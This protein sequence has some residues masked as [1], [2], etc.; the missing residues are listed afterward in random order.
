MECL[1]V[2]LDWQAEQARLQL[3]NADVRWRCTWARTPQEA[4]LRV[5]RDAPDVLLLCDAACAPLLEALHAQPPLCA[6]W[7]LADGWT[8]D[9][10][11]ASFTAL[12]LSKMPALL[13]ALE[14]QGRLPGLIQSWLPQLHALATELLDM[15]G[16]PHRLGAWAFLPD[17][18]ALCAAHPGTLT[19]LHHRFY[20][21]TGAR[22]QLSPA[23]VERRLR[24]AVESTWNRGNVN[25]LETCFGQSIDPERGKPTNK[26]FLC[27]SSEWIALAAQRE[28]TLPAG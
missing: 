5:Q 19:D 3:E 20:P 2:G 24:I 22:H 28:I 11:D 25:A 27:R 13:D 21:M 15:L 14:R 8:P 18:L 6:P 10:C 16:M 17:M 12:D 9:E 7:I 4:L 26:E 1:V 23:C